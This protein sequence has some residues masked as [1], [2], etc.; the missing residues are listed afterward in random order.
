MPLPTLLVKGSIEGI[1]EVPITYIT[2]WLKNHMYE[3][4]HAS[5]TLND[6]ILVIQA[7][8]GSGKSTILPVEVFRILRNK[9]VPLGTRYTG[10]KVICTQ[11]RVL[12]AIELAKDVTVR[13][14]DMVVGLTV[15]YHTKPAVEKPRTG[16]IYAT[17]G[18][19]SRQLTVFT[20]EMLMK[21][22]K[23]IIIDE[24]H[25]RTMG[26]DIALFMLYHFYKRNVGNKNLP[27][28]ILTSAT[29]D[30]KKY[31]DYFNI[32][33]DNMILIS[34][35][36]Y[37]IITNWAP[38]DINN[39]LMYTCDVVKNICLINDPV[40]KA[41]VLIFVPGA[42]ETKSLIEALKKLQISNVLILKLDSGAVEHNTYDYK[43]LFT[44]QNN[45]P[46]KNNKIPRRIIVST[47]VAET[48]LTI[49]TC[50]YVIDYGYHRSMETYP[51]YNATGLIT[52][53]APQSRITQRRGRVGR[54]FD[55]VFYP[56]YT[57]ESY[58]LLDKQQL[59]EIF[60]SSN[61]Y[62][63][64]H[65]VFHKILGKL[66]IDK[67]NLLDP[68][69]IETFINANSIATLLG[70]IDNNSL[71]TNL[72]KIA[73]KFSSISMEHAKIIFSGFINNVAIL[74]LV[75]ICALMKSDKERL[76]M[77]FRKYKKHMEEN[78][79]EYNK[80]IPCCDGY[81]L[82]ESLPKFIMEGSTDEYY[83]KYKLL[84]CDE[85]IESLFI[86]E[87]FINIIMKYKDVELVEMWCMDNCLNFSELQTVYYNRESIIDELLASG[88]DILYNNEFRII[89]QDEIKF[90]E[91]LI[92]IKKCIY[93][94]LKNNIIIYDEDTK[95]YKSLKG[96]L[97]II[98][99]S[100]ILNTQ[101]QNKLYAAGTITDYITPKYMITDRFII[102]QNMS[103]EIMYSINTNYISILD[104]YIY[105]DLLL[106][107]PIYD[108]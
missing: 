69:S 71:L 29:I 10:Q 52:K 65:L 56:T 90:M 36:S 38:N 76:F 60:T 103:E 95:F 81:A 39:L 88:I 55:G 79:L 61:E 42:K 47:A 46:K 50:K 80:S 73:S 37:D 44:D 21:E 77:T 106:G 3:Y 105:P 74:D 1:D 53:P 11:P 17:L 20:D 87:S 93:E 104:G 101:L 64:V 49:G 51:L 78:N 72:G 70:F 108:N 7:K 27:F 2:N 41:D 5:A 16:L 85:F 26:S 57:E 43:M 91:S 100:S 4:G 30:T 97:R 102:S 35:Q 15:G 92:N 22:Y 107:Q 58:N 82:H 98:V 28:L 75:T 31:A 12:T 66:E 6:R 14:K 68:P 99:N 23:F 19:L 96:D 84:I 24:A 45:L 59:P 33:Y 94:G 34:G 13:N 63:Y 48:G 89:H 67:L 9:D 8:T 54:L 40:D 25:E 18:I 83:Y 86:F 32:S 62:N